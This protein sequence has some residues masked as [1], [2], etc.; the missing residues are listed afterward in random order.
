MLPGA[1]DKAIYVAIRPNGAVN[2]RLYSIDYDTEL[3]VTLDGDKPDQ[4]WASY[5]FGIVQEMRKLGATIEGFDCVFGGDVPLGAGLSSSAALE[6]SFGY[7]L[8]DLFGNGLSRADLANAGQMTEHNY[9]GVRCG[10]MD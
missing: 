7:A 1:I 9:V 8:N 3:S 4:Q 2:A 10:I 6:R 5:V